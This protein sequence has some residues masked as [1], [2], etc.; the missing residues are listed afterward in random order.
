[1]LNNLNSWFISWEIKRGD[2]DVVSLWEL[3]RAAVD[4]AATRTRRHESGWSQRSMRAPTA[5]RASYYGFF[6]SPRTFAAYDSTNTKFLKTRFPELAAKL[7]LNATLN[8][9]Q[10]LANTEAVADWLAD[11]DSPY[12]S[13]P[14]LSQ[15]AYVD[16][17][18]AEPLD[19]DMMVEDPVPSPLTR[20]SG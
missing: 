10:F 14:E 5:A 7:S 17:A 13:F 18:A 4:Y 12:D 1:M 6:E 20:W 16:L 11:P 2:R 9:E 15:A 8:G 19:W 3:A